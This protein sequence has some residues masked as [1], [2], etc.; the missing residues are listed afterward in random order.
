MSDLTPRQRECMAL[1]DRG[2]MA[3]Q[4]GPMLGISVKTVGCHIEQAVVR[5]HAKTTAHA[6]V[7]YVREYE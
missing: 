4:I 3:K 1:I 5:L 6:A 7:L 2:F